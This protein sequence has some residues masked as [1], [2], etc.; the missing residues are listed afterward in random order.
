MKKMCSSFLL[1]VIAILFCSSCLAAD[2]RAAIREA[3]TKTYP[4]LHVGEIRETPISGLYEIETGPNVLYYYPDKELILFGEL[5]TKEGRS[6]TA[7]RKVAL[8]AQRIKDIPLEKG[9]KIG[10]GKHTVVEFTDPDCPYCRKASEFLGTRK[11]TTRYVYLLPLPIHKDAETKA[12]FILCAHDQAKAYE[13]VMRGIHDKEKLDAC[14]GERASALL[15]EHKDIAARAGV[16]GTPSFWIDGHAVV[17][18]NIPAL[19]KLL[20]EPTNHKEK[21]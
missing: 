6:L 14:S 12:R 16:G 7:E 20:D 11:D 18:A 4:Q 13:E 8:S 21:P 3:L 9:I 10:A 15:H 5:W 17:G 2:D 19:E 1:L